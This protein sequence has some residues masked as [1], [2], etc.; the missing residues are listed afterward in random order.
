[1]SIS[2]SRAPPNS[3]PT[4]HPAVALLCSS[5]NVDENVIRC[6]QC[7]QLTDTRYRNRNRA[8]RALLL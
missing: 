2:S 7:G 1:L 8:H 6:E 3:L 4:Q 5:T